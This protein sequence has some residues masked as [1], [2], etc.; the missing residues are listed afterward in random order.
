[1]IKTKLPIGRYRLF[2]L[3]FL[4]GLGALAF[5][6]HQM[7]TKNTGHIPPTRVIMDQA[8]VIDQG[9]Q[10]NWLEAQAGTY[11]V[12]GYV[13]ERSRGGS[14]FERVARV[15][16]ISLEYLDANGQDGDT[17][18][19]IAEDSHRPISRSPVSELVV[20]APAKPGD[21]VVISPPL[22]Q[23]VLGT[24]TA[25]DQASTPEA[26]A[27]AL[28]SLMTKGFIEFDAA[29]ADKDDTSAKT[30]LNTLQ[31]YHRQILSLWPQVPSAQKASLAQACTE[32]S[33]IFGTNLYLLAERDQLD[34]LLVLAGCDAIRDGI[35]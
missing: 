14:D 18:R 26:K 22:S 3:L 1:V 17:Y 4:V 21:T 10:L 25:L 13:I 20:A 31:E 15:E 19:V 30:I 2:A 35:R 5:P 8:L 32:H 16:K 29:A 27:A 24:S 9:V 33:G 12:G 34:G 23:K 11:P 7:Q 6:W 28:Q